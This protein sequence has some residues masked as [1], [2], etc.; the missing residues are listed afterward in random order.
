MVSVIRG[1]EKDILNEKNQHQIKKVL[2]VQHAVHTSAT[3][4][5]VLTS[6]VMMTDPARAARPRA[7]RYMTASPALSVVRSLTTYEDEPEY[8]VVLDR[9]PT[10]PAQPAA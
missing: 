7:C 1:F 4:T 9:F 10:D 2:A 8:V 5:S 6:L 3:S